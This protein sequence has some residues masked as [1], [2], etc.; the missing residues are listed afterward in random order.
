M[1]RINVLSWW[2]RL[3][4]KHRY[5]SFH[6]WPADLGVYEVDMICV[7]CGEKILLEV[8]GGDVLPTTG[9]LSDEQWE[10]IRS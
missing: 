6:K 3:R 1:D 5:V 9:S 4:C 8:V 2:K 10:L 7:W